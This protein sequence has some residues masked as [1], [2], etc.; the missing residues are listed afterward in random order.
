MLERIKE[1]IVA[2]IDNTG[3]KFN[4]SILVSVNG[5][6]L[7]SNGYGYANFEL[8]VKNTEKTKFRI[9]SITKQFTAVAIMQLVEKGL[10]SVDDTLDKFIVDYPKGNEITI[11]HL[12]THTSGIVNF[13]TLKEYSII[14]VNK[15]TIEELIE[16]FKQLPLNFEPGLKFEYS[17]SGYIILS[18]IIE[19]VTNKKYGEYIQEYIFDKLSMKN[20]GDDIQS[21]I[22]KNRANGYCKDKD[23]K[24]LCNSE[25]IDM[26][27]VKGDGG[28]YSTIEDLHIWNKALF[29][30][31]VISKESLK[32]ITTPYIAQDDSNSYGYG[33]D[34]GTEE[35]SGK[36]RNIIYHGGE[37]NG[38][39]CTNEVFL[40]ENVEIIALSNIRDG[41]V[42]ELV[43]NIEEIILKEF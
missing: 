32:A 26:S 28:L 41:F 1:N 36:L 35:I 31:N 17:N 13:T 27:H 25:Y 40:D 16:I 42:F 22:L 10:L 19:K 4:G 34:L 39:H 2:Y 43:E 7:I 37:I 15:Y 21:K 24:E 38:F 5:E 23:S 11:H 8:D 33:L 3:K 18:Y 6:K 29:S 14:M 20:S 12:L 30:G 9:C